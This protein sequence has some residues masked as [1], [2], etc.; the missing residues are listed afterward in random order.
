MTKHHQAK[1]SATMSTDTQT[2]SFETVAVLVAALERGG[3]KLGMSHYTLM[4]SLSGGSRSASSFDHG[5]RKVKARARELAG[6]E[7]AGTPG[8]TPG[9]GKTGGNGGGR[10]RSKSTLCRYE[11][12]QDADDEEIEGSPSK[13]SK[14]KVEV[15]A[16]KVE[17]KGDGEGEGDAGSG[18]DVFT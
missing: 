7:G 1:P 18:E 11:D 10:K 12:T 13:K 8:P 16:E 9:K 14:A 3:V 15:K 5:F 17:E 2:F 6:R 4:A